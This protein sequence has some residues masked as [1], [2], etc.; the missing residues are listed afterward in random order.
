MQ[1]IYKVKSSSLCLSEQMLKLNSLYC[2]AQR[3]AEILGVWE[4]CRPDGG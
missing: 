1:E 3:K 2:E 4:D